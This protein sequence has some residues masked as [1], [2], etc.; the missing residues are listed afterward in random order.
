VCGGRSTIARCG[1]VDEGYPRL[2]ARAEVHLDYLVHGMLT[3]LEP[4]RGISKRYRGW[5]L[6][7]A[8]MA[9]QPAR[10]FR[11]G[12]AECFSTSG[13]RSSARS[14]TFPVGSASFALTKAA[15]ASPA[16]FTHARI[17]LGIW[18]HIATGA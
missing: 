17:A 13:T 3:V 14:R 10:G 7:G 8:E 5:E 15:R 1:A 11:L 2:A 12:H 16:T 9:A 4:G 6:A 18:T